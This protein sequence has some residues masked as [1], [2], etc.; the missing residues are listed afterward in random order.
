LQ[1]KLACFEAKAEPGKKPSAILFLFEEI[2]ELK[3]QLRLK[4]EKTSS[5]KKSTKEG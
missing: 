3:R 5:S 1:S 4:P 2:N